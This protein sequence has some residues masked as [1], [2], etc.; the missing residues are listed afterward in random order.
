MPATNHVDKLRQAQADWE[1]NTPL[2]K[3]GPR[4]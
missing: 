3:P 1:A 4:P 2:E